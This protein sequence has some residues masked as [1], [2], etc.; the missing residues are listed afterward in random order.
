MIYDGQLSHSAIHPDGLM[1]ALLALE[2]IRDSAVILHGPTGCRG[3]HSAL[4]ECAFPR[5]SIVERLNY[6]EPYYFG[7][8]RIPCTYLDADDYVFGAREKLQSAIRVA[9]SH[10][11][12]FIGVVNSPGAALIGEDLSR[13]LADTVNEIPSAV[14]DMPAIS[15]PMAEGHQQSIIAVL[16]KLDFPRNS[17]ILPRTVSLVGVSITHQH[18]AGSLAELRRLLG[19]CG[20]Q[21]LCAIGAGSPIAEWRSLSSAACHLVVHAEYGN[22]VAKWLKE[23]F[24]TPS[25]SL[26]SGA[27]IGFTAAEEWVIEAARSVGGDPSDA[28]EAIRNQRRMVSQQLSRVTGITGAPKGMSCSINTDPSIALPLARFL[29]DYLGILPVSVETPDH[30]DSFLAQCL[31]R[32]L[33]EIRCADAWQTSWQSTDADFLLADGHQVSQWNALRGPRGSVELSLSLGGRVDF[34]PKSLLGAQGAAY[35]VETIFNAIPGIM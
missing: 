21:V 3:F 22:R 24:G 5:G 14:V 25:V 16:E 34:I 29:Y 28:V 9:L 2:G 23:R 32:F 8:P 19:L 7:Q 26:D 15:R 4:S 11:P 33:A 1:G 12:G 30:E 31:E 20:I 35:L 17:T 27:P 6:Q 13:A 10:K 18:W